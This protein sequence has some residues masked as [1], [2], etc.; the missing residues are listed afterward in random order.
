M[1]ESAIHASRSLGAI[2]E[3]VSGISP[4]AGRSRIRG[5]L[6]ERVQ[7]LHSVASGE[8]L[9]SPAWDDSI[10]LLFQEIARAYLNL[11]GDSSEA[12]R[13]LV[14]ARELAA[15]PQLIESIERDQ[16]SL[17]RAKLCR[18]AEKEIQHARERFQRVQ[19]TPKKKPEPADPSEDQRQA[20]VKEAETLVNFGDFAAADAKLMAALALSSLPQKAEMQAV[21]DR[22]QWARVLW[23]IDTSRKE[24]MLSAF[25]GTGARFFGKQDYDMPT[26]SYVTNHWIIFL[27]IPIFPIGSYR[28]SDAGFQSYNIYGK[29][30]LPPSLKTGRW[31]A[32]GFITVTVLIA[33]LMMKP[34]HKPAPKPPTIVT[35]APAPA[36]THFASTQTPTAAPDLTA[37]KQSLEARKEKLDREGADL[38]KRASYLDTVAASYSG[39]NVPAAAR[40]AYD[41]VRAQY[42]WKLMKHKADV[43]AYQRDNEAY[44]RQVNP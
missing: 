20:L 19:P 39:Q 13:L 1:E 23:G 10:A 26:R 3:G 41:A 15:D 31:C 38:E 17:A 21:R 16:R 24:P 44:L 12:G 8:L 28:V 22:F 37:L 2:L 11:L 27:G 32:L 4:R 29:T 18:D 43:A 33:A 40:A 34:A 35:R 36:V 42:R 14:K 30:H 7:E 6:A 25:Y 9:D 5:L